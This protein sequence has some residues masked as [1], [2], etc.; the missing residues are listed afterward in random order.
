MRSLDSLNS[1]YVN[2]FPRIEIVFMEEETEKIPEF[3][4]YAGNTYAYQILDIPTFYEVLTWERDTPGV[5]YMW[6]GNIITSYNG[7][8]EYAFKVDSLVKALGK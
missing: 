3:F 1:I 5:F 8:N 7:I 2:D 4:E 6:N